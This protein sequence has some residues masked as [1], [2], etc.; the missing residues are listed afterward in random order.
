MKKVLRLCFLFVLI[1]LA[2]LENLLTA[3]A[4]TMGNLQH[5]G[6]IYY[7]N[8]GGFYFAECAENKG[9]K[10]K[11]LGLGHRVVYDHGMVRFSEGNDALWMHY[12]CY[13]GLENSGWTKFGAKDINNT[14]AIG[15]MLPDIYRIDTDEGITMYLIK[16]EYDLIFEDRYVVIAHQKDGKWVKYMDSQEIG[17]Q[18]FGKAGWGLWAKDFIIEGNKI[19]LPYE[20]YGENYRHS[21]K[22]TESGKFVL[23]WDENTQW[24]AIDKIV[25]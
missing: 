14:L 19:T 23:Q 12:Q 2:C 20:L 10:C 11:E 15:I 17:Q 21:S 8:V 7:A 22:P 16:D 18:Y 3:K 9:V 13:T 6:K 4:M 25:Y 5:V 24:F 1:M